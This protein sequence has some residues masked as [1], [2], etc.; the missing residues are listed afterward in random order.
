MISAR[1]IV[2]KLSEAKLSRTPMT[3][4]SI[5][6]SE[7]SLDRQQADEPRRNTPPKARRGLVVVANLPAIFLR[8]PDEAIALQFDTIGFRREGGAELFGQA[9]GERRTID[10][11]ADLRIQI[12]RT[13]IEI[14][15]ADEERAAIEGKGLCVEARA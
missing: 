2:I 9:R 15:G 3:K 14:E 10:Q 4:R 12:A 11:Q 5:C 7:L 6:M 1:P 8:H 13:W